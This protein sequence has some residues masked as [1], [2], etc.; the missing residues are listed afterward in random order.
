MTS[1][2][3]NRSHRVGK[4]DNQG[5]TAATSRTRHP[6]TIVKFATYNGRHRQI[7]CARKSVPQKF[8]DE[9]LIKFQS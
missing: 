7:A 6:D 8:I 4:P 1:A 3:I 9:V 2:D 5:H